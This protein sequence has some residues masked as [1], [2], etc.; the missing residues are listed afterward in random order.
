MKRVLVAVAVMLMLLPG[1]ALAKLVV[2]DAW[3]RE[4]PPGSRMLAAY[5][6]LKNTEPRLRVVRSIRSADFQRV[7]IHRSTHE[8]GMMRMQHL[9]KLRLAPGQLVHMRPGSLHLMLI[10]PKRT[11]RAGDVVEFELVAEDG[12]TVRF[13]ADV[14]RF[15]RGD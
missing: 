13:S 10:G 1:V 5:L 12:E 3:V 2:S 6:A 9:D 7:E 14:R 8:Q 4:A 11:L 15:R